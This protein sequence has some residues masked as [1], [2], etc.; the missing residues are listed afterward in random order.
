MYE[1]EH[2]EPVQNILGEGP[3][4]SVSEQRLYWI[5][6]T[7][8]AFFRLNPAT[9]EIETFELELVIG[10]MAPNSDGRIIM[11]TEDGLALWDYESRRMTVLTDNIAHQPEGRFNDGKVDRRG[12]FW[13]GTMA[14][15]PTGYFYKVE[16]D[17]S[18]HQMERGI[19]TSNG[20]GWSP[21]NTIMYYCDSG[22]ATIYAYDFDIDAGTLSNRRIFRKFD[23][24]N[25]GTSD[26]L[27]VDA[28]G[29]LWVAFWDGWRV[30]R[31][32][33]DG[34]IDREIKMPVQRPTSCIFGG[35][36]LDILYVTSA[37]EGLS[38]ADMA[39]QPLAG[40][41]FRIQTDVKGLPEPVANIKFDR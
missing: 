26:G 11:A 13:A 34:E 31:F 15:Q 22:P 30:V 20:L 8:K 40:G 33:P 6:I 29:Y 23:R 9:G 10:S 21:D 35:P 24:P 19:K 12:R 7:G 4:W 1:V 36:D 17:G 41:L 32:S 25:E 27:T 39:G 2:I 14:P 3:W 38:E 5:D 28:E 16:L 37:R 18:V